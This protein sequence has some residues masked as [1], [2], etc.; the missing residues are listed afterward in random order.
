[1]LSVCST[2]PIPGTAA[3]ASRCSALFHMNVP[4]R[5]SPVTPSERS[6]LA[7]RAARRPTSPYV[8]LRQPVPVHV[9]TCASECTVVAYRTIVAIDSGASIIVLRMRGLLASA[10]S[11]RVNPGVIMRHRRIRLSGP[12]RNAKIINLTVRQTRTG[13][14]RSGAQAF[15]GPQRKVLCSRSFLTSVPGFNGMSAVVRARAQRGR[16][17]APAGF[18]G[19]PAQLSPARQG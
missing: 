15:S 16:E 3:Y 8:R 6:P 4:T 9:R 17:P 14:S 13:G 10:G 12:T 2:A 11:V 19:T 7:S 18:A 1:M 5:S